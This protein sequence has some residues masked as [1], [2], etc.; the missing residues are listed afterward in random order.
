MITII[1]PSKKQDFSQT[2]ITKHT[3]PTQLTHS[4]ELIKTLL[5]LS[6]DDLA[7]L[8]S[9]SQNLS[10]L[11]HARYRDF[12]TPFTLTNAK[13]ALLAFKGDVY[14]GIE[15]DNYTDLDFNFAQQNLRILSGLYGVLKPL[16]LIQPYRLEMGV[17]LTNDRGKN[18]YQFWGDKLSQELNSDE[19]E[20]IVNLASQEYFKGIDKKSLN[21]KILQIDFK[22]N[23]DG[24]YK[25][26]GIHAKRAR[27]LMVSYIIKNRLTKPDDLKKFNGATY[28]FNAEFSSDNHW[29]FTR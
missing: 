27:G 11:N 28:A 17:K 20:V 8:M 5:P 13:Q 7:G 24:V 15:V 9:I 1:S 6:V 26:I 2:S 29:V 16:D 4:Q 12:A 23:K 19:S 3:T 10:E 21:A 14:A 22:E 18:L 25:I